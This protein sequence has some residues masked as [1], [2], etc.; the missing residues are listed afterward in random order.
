[1]THKPVYCKKQDVLEDEHQTVYRIK[2]D[3][4]LQTYV[5]GDLPYE[6]E[7]LINLELVGTYSGAY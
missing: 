4:Y 1:M 7:V 6:P 5:L 2:R 3:T